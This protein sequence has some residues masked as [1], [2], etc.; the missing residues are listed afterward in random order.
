MP[1]SDV[2]DSCFLGDEDVSQT[3][4][5][6]FLLT[7]P[8]RMR[9]DFNIFISWLVVDLVSLGK[10]IR[11]VNVLNQASS[12]T[13]SNS[14]TKRGQG[15][16]IIARTFVTLAALALAAWL[17]V[18][19]YMVSHG[20]ITT[21][22]NDTYQSERL[23]ADKEKAEAEVNFARESGKS[24]LE[25]SQ[26]LQKLALYYRESGNF[27]AAR[28][29][30]MAADR[31]VAA[32]HDDVLHLVRRMQLKREAAMVM[33]ECG[34]FQEAEPLFRQAGRLLR[35]LEKLDGSAAQ[36]ARAALRNDQGVLYYLWGNATRELPLRFERLEIARRCF[37][38]SFAGV[39]G[40]D[41]N[42]ASSLRKAV[43]R[44]LKV[45]SEDLKFEVK[46]YS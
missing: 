12:Q 46:T 30:L 3:F 1:G 39:K 43:A 35:P 27:A 15:R 14:K 16:R 7:G 9:A 31:S 25:L 17:A 6:S 34:L 13:K 2:F 36:M 24:A 11:E 8:S 19:V 45:L 38:E 22:N 44:N 28:D 21:Y 20:G 32:E 26:A 42:E 37:A 33:A 40:V 29:T 10:I 23:F 4:V 5:C 18:T 41:S